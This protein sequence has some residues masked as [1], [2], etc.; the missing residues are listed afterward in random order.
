MSRP[1]TFADCL[2]NVARWLDQTDPIINERTNGA[3]ASGNE[4][5]TDLR[6][7]AE[8]LRDDPLLD[9]QIMELMK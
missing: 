5:Q 7:V 9:A 4:V 6:R 8:R 2:D 1:E 3:V